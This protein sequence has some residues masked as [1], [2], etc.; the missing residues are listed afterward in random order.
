[1]PLIKSIGVS[2]ESLSK[3]WFLTL[4]EGRGPTSPGA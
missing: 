2:M 3:S 1:L 4:W